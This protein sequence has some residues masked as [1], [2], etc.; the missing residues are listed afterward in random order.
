[1][2]S[3][4]AASSK[5]GRPKV[6]RSISRISKAG[7]NFPVGRVNKLLKK[8]KYADRVY[9]AASVHLTA[10]LEYLASEVIIYVLKL[11]GDELANNKKNR[12]Q[13]RHIL[14]AV[15]KDR[16]WKQLLQNVT[17]PDAVKSPS[18]GETD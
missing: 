11:A 15:R 14:Q 2:S 3:T 5:K 13:P 16:E 7:L 1:M 18:S 17:I 10:V 9:T 4:G 6:T 12:I 8:G